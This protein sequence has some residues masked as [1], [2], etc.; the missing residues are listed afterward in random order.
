MLTL[1]GVARS[2]ASRPIWLLNELGVPYRHIPVI[3]SYR[4]PDPLAE[5]APR[6]TASPEF[7]AINPMGQI[8]VLE[9]DGLILTESLAICQHIARTQGGPLA[10]ATP[11]EAALTDQWALFGVAELEAPGLDILFTYAD[12]LN[13]NPEGS[14]KIDT[15]C[16]RLARPLAR[17][18][19]HLAHHEWLT[20][21][22]FTVADL[23]L[24]ECLRYAATHAPLMDSHPKTK[25]WLTRC[26]ARP[27]FKAMWQARIAEP[28]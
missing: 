23:M 2:R 27:A 5:G 24:A 1:Y 9:D 21:T 13:D 22:R 3:Q 28:A 19:S 14:A 16:A 8:P 11:A 18:E 25:A 20:G 15:A 12:K 6:N 4:L 7:R 26:Q 17:L 10:P